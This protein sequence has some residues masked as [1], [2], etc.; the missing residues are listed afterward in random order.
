M[1]V[2]LSTS[3][4]SDATRYISDIFDALK[5]TTGDGIFCGQI[6]RT[7]IVERTNSGRDSDGNSFAPYS[8]KYAAAKEKKLGHTNIDLF[9]ADSHPHMLNGIDV[10]CGGSVAGSNDNMPPDTNTLTTHAES[11][12]V[13]IYDEELAQRASLHNE[14]GQMR[15]RLGNSRNPKYKPRPN[16]QSIANMPRRHFFDVNSDDVQLIENKVAERMEIRAKRAAGQST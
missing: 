5:F 11:F 16:A 3:A 9:G 7:R 2:K 13:G 14:G 1:Q 4:G 6:I 15:T 8:D 12:Q 10:R